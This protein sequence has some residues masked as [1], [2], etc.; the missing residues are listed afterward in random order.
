MSHLL[1]RPLVPLT[2][3]AIG[4][5]ILLLLIIAI[6]AY[7][8]RLNQLLCSTPDEI[9]RLRP[10]GWTRDTLLAMYRRLESDPITTRSYA[11]RIPP[12][13]ERRYIITGGSGA[14]DSPPCAGAGVSDQ[15]L[16]VL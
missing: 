10:A 9:R 12:K 16:Q 7:L 15:P 6:A 3:P 14:P 2:S 4:I 13:L 11:D 1:Y 5:V 8:A